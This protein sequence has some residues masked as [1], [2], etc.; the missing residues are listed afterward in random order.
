MHIKYQE[1]RYEEWIAVSKYQF[2]SNQRDSGRMYNYLLA[3]LELLSELCLDKN[4]I[5]IFN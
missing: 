4:Y 1:D 3:M 2:N 5:G